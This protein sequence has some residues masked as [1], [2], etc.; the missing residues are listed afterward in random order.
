MSATAGMPSAAARRE[1]FG[2]ERPLLQGEARPDV[3]VDEGESAT[4]VSLKEDRSR[5]RTGVRVY[6]RSPEG[7]IVSRPDRAG[8]Y[9]AGEPVART[10][11]RWAW[12]RVPVPSAAAPTDRPSSDPPDNRRA[13]R[14]R[15]S[16]IPPSPCFAHD[17]HLRID[18]VEILD[19]GPPNEDT[20]AGR[21]DVI[22]RVQFE[23]AG[24]GIHGVRL[25]QEQVLLVG[26]AGG[27][28]IQY[29][30]PRS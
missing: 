9:L 6:Q 2:R 26:I 14:P 3:E 28:R 13:R 27:I 17:D 11:C 20:R 29:P 25:G 12:R 8:C 21:H 18:E 4:R 23:L 7:R 10:R 5:T 16:A 24:L 30:R 19:L 1:L 22:V 15:M